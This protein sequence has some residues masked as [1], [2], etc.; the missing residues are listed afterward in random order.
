M[1]LTHSINSIALRR[2]KTLLSFGLSEGNRVKV[3]GYTGRGSN[4]SDTFASLLSRGQLFKETI[5]R[6]KFLSLRVDPIS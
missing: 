4:S 3:S 2:A 6:S 1:S 5:S